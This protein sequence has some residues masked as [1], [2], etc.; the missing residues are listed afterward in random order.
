MFTVKGV[1]VGAMHG[2]GVSMHMCT[3]ADWLVELSTEHTM[4]TTTSTAP[5]SSLKLADCRSNGRQCHRDADC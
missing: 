3:V 2:S 5:V 4:P 1:G